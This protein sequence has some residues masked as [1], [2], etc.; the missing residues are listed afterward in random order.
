MIISGA[1]LWGLSGPMI[2]WL[3]SHSNLSPENFLIVRLILAGSF[4]LGY[5]FF[6]K[7]KVF[8]VWKD[9][10]DWIQVVIFAVLGMLGAQYAFIESITASNAVTATLFQF[11]GPVLITIYVAIQNKKLPSTVHIL[12]VFTAL[13]GLFFLITNGSIEN[14]VLS[15]RAIYLGVLTMLGFTF[16][17]LHPASLIK[18]WGTLNIV[19][20][21]MLIG[22]IVLLLFN[23]KFSVQVLTK[24]LTISTFFIMSLA[25]VIGTISFLL[26]I[27]SLKYLSPTETSI[28]S[29][30]EPFVAAIISITWLNE[31][32]GVY[33]I[34]GG[35]F[36]I[37]AV[38]FLTLPQKREQL[39]EKVKMVSEERELA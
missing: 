10:R 24:T 37:I 30:I 25:I 23:Q 6:A 11:F 36:I 15:R 4:I 21:G 26:Y 17:T 34:V 31:S 32:F 39:N 7:K 8:M 27:G 20:W 28:L 16:Y 3:F 9:P 2:Q 35:A 12:S 22:G 14:I 19:G 1:T 33:Q 13:I 5:L 29:S 18:K 38:I